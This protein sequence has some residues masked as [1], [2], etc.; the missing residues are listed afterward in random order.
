MLAEDARRT[1]LE[2][3]RAAISAGVAGHP[4]PPLDLVSLPVELRAE[5]ACFVTLTRHGNLRGCIGSLEARRALAL[6]VREHAQDAALQDYRF[7]PVTA[8]EL[9]SLHIEIS[10]LTKPEPLAYS[11][12]EELARA[13]KPGVDGVI[14]AQ[15]RQRAT[16]LPQVWEQLPEAQ[17]FLSHLCEKMGAAPDLWRKTH[18]EVFTYQVE[19]FE[20]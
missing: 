10:V 12:A 7:P 4:A 3:A 9:D 20:E 14:L 17:I 8:A 13:L 18:L 19:C 1:L 2:I 6:D 15:G 11:T 16:F 5:G